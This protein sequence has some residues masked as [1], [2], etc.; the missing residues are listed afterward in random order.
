MYDPNARILLK[1]KPSSK[2]RTAHPFSDV[3]ASRS[4][5][6]QSGPNPLGPFTQHITSGGDNNSRAGL[7][8][9][10]QSGPSGKRQQILCGHRRGGLRVSK[11][12]LRVGSKAVL[13]HTG[14][15]DPFPPAVP[16]LSATAARQFPAAG[17]AG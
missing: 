6:A 2:D 12:L 9:V 5:K 14:Q 3:I 17:R 1:P 8:A 11:D 15:E 16:G 4:K 10:T 13:L 7:E